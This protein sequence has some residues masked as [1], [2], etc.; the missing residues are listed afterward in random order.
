MILVLLMFGGLVIFAQSSP[1]APFIFSWLFLIRAWP[2]T[3][4]KPVGLRFTNRVLA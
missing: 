1:G 3:T 2:T 4:R